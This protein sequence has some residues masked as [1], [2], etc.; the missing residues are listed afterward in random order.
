MAGPRFP[1]VPDTPGVPPVYRDDSNPATPPT[2]AAIAT[3]DSAQVQASAHPAWAIVK[4]GGAAAIGVD[5][6]VE[7]SP[8]R[9]F[10]ISDYPVEN[11]GFQNYNKVALPAE[12]RV[13]VTKEG[14]DSDRQGFFDQLDALIETTDMVNIVTPDSSYLDRN[15]VRYNFDRRADR[16]RA[17]IT[18]ELIFQEIRQ[19]A[20]SAFT[21]SKQ[22]SGNDPVNDGPVQ[23]GT[24]TGP[25]TPPGPP[26]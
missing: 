21:D 18:V 3:T 2:P 8:S 19:T 14:N 5:S 6:I 12:T 22:P 10:R 24:P 4:A 25:Q 1:D 7:L 20:K 13:L 23:P 16:G 9:D 17:L 26:A 15:L 11:G